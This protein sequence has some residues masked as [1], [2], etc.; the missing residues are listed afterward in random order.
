MGWGVRSLT[1]AALYGR[2]N[3][4]VAAICGCGRLAVAGR[5][6]G[7]FSWGVNRGGQFTV[8]GFVLGGF[9]FRLRRGRQVF[10]P[11]WEENPVYRPAEAV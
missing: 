5:Q 10:G 2:G 7:F 6:N 4:A 1:V 8:S 9:G 11:E 3:L